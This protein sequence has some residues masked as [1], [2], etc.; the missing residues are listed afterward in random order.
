LFYSCPDGGVVQWSTHPPEVLREKH[1]NDKIDI[2]CIVCF[3][4]NKK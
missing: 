4:Y 2:V 3:V 1:S